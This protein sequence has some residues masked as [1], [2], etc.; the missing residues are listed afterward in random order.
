MGRKT[1]TCVAIVGFLLSISLWGASYFNM[2]YTSDYEIALKKGALLWDERGLNPTGVTW[3]T[4]PS[5]NEAPR[6]G[7]TV[8]GIQTFETNWVPAAEK[9]EVTLPLWIPTLI[10]VLVF[11]WWSWLPLIRRGRRVRF[12][13]CAACG[14]DLRAT[15]ADRCPECGASPRIG[16]AWY[17]R[18]TKHQKLLTVVSL[19]GIVL[20]L[21]LWTLSYTRIHYKGGS[22]VTYLG[23]GRLLYR[24]TAEP[25]PPQGWTWY[26]VRDRFTLW[27]PELTYD[28]WRGL[29]LSVP[30]WMPLS[31]LAV[32]F[33]YAGVP[34]L[35]RYGKAAKSA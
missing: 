3:T 15:E 24:A 6:I 26:G 23:C 18:S 7:F 25:E 21:G 5:G 11:F 2:S 13:R 19:S 14:Y 1:L 16:R 35:W 17:N 30:M 10:S 27:A 32:L 9:G 20:C 22:F 34:L 31:L 28:S 33:L 12:G 8:R 29:Y 4:P